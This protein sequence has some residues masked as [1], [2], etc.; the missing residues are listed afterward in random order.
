M[1]KEQYAGESM[2]GD[3][4][5]EIN[6]DEVGNPPPEG[7]YN[8]LFEKTEYKPTSKGKHMIKCQLKIEAAVDPNH[9]EKSV[10]R[11]VFTNFNFFQD[12]AFGVKLF[13]NAL[14]IPLPRQVNK[15]ALEDWAAEHL[16]GVV[17]GATLKHR[18][19]NGAKQ[20]DISNFKPAFDVSGTAID[21]TGGGDEPADEEETQ[22]AEGEE[23][24]ESMPAE[25]EEP[26]PEPTPT[27]SIRTATATAPKNGHANGTNGT[28]KSTKKTEP[29]KK[30]AAQARR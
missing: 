17:C 29:A 24:E 5:E 20:P 23:E 12:G 27:R 28:A 3:Y 11:T 6:W 25:D 30:S 14:E 2:N 26:E 1:P 10:G 9:E 18:D 13:A 15:A 19:W 22:A 7:E 16:L 8:F 4:T 21:T